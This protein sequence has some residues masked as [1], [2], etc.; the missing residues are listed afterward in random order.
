MFKG[1]KPKSDKASL[2]NFYP[3]AAMRLFWVNKQST[4][5][6]FRPTQ[7]CLTK[8]LNSDDKSQTQIINTRLITFSIN[9]ASD[10]ISS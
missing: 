10:P 2:F 5:T 7:R 3:N 1:K 4:S 9:P 8:G 6:A